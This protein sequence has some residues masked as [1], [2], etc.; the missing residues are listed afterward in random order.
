ML[1]RAVFEGLPTRLQM[2]S[3]SWRELALGWSLNK[4]RTFKS[5][6]VVGPLT[7]VR[8]KAI[9]NPEIS[10]K[11]R[12]NAE[13]LR[14]VAMQSAVPRVASF[15]V[16][17]VRG[18]GVDAG[19][20]GVA[21]V[22]AQAAF[23]YIGA[24]GVRPH[25]ILFFAFHVLQLQLQV[26]VQRTRRGRG[27]RLRARKKKQKITNEMIRFFFYSACSRLIAGELG[28]TLRLGLQRRPRCS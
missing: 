8:S 15:T 16:A 19:G 21:V 7:K 11:L 27:L 12:Q 13:P 14:L 10:F 18:G 5:A 3:M 25:G 4:Q 28:L 9:T 1:C 26:H 2:L 20:E 17:F 23:F 22:E 24:S 6:F